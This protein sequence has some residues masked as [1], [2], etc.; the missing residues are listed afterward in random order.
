MPAEF[1]RQWLQSAAGLDVRAVYFVRSDQQLNLDER[2]GSVNPV[3]GSF[4]PVH[5]I[6]SQPSVYFVWVRA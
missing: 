6:Q 4:G 5:W 2:G 1:F 3:D